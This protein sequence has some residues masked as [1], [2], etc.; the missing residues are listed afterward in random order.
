MRY[1][2]RHAEKAVRTAANDFPVAFV[3]GPRQVGKTTMLKHMAGPGVDYV[4]LDDPSELLAAREEPGLFFKR[5][6]QPLIIDEVQYAPGLFSYVKMAADAGKGNGRIYLT[7]SQSF[8]MMKNISDSLAGRVGIINLPGISLREIKRSSLRAPFIPD[9]GYL[10]NFKGRPPETGYEELFKIIHRGSMPAMRDEKK[11]WNLFYSSYV[12]TYIQRDVRD[13]T[14]VGDELA[15]IKFMSVAAARTGQMLNYSEMARDVGVSLPTAER[16]LSVL[17]ASQ[18]VYLLQPFYNNVT[19]RAIK[20]PKL[21][22]MDT[23]LAAY[24][25]KWTDPRVLEAGSMSGAFFETF[26]VSEIL[27]SYYNAGISDPPLYYYRDKEM[28]EID[29]IV[30]RNGRLHPVEI[31][32]T[33]NPRRE[34]I[35]NFYRLD[36]IP[37]VSRGEGALI[38]MYDRVLPLDEDN[39]AVPVSYV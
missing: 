30:E 33:A 1:I 32:K 22:F 6:R 36:G 4:T 15:F 3:A 8:H 7:G 31:K 26:I 25:T 10:S 29:L 14:Q 21:Y 28:R 20:T 9:A 16:W 19:R 2:K 17:V 18:I 35:S 23:G 27:K 24:L 34:D 37:G 13:L 39:N 11:D 12:K 5:R 38:C